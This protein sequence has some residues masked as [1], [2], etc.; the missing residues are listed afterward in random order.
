[1]STRTLKRFSVHFLI[2]LAMLLIPSVASAKSTT[3]Q[4]LTLLVKNGSTIYRVKLTPAAKKLLLERLKMKLS[5]SNLR[6]G[7][8]DEWDGWG[9]CFKTC[10][11]SFGVSPVQVVLCAAACG[12]T[13]GVMCAICIGVDVSIIELCALGCAVYAN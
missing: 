8:I 3:K 7:P 6:P 2:A 4:A 12:V 10:L 9:G 5:R 11:Q 1:M 13:A